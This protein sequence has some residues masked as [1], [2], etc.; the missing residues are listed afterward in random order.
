MPDSE[1]RVSMLHW[2]PLVQGADVPMPRT[3]LLLLPE[4]LVY[5]V[6]DGAEDNDADLRFYGV[7]QDA[8]ER[9]GLPLFMRS[10]LTSGKHDYRTT[11][12]VNDLGDVVSHACAVIE[13]TWLGPGEPAQAIVLREL[14]DLD[15]PFTAFDGRLPIARERRLFVADGKTI[16]RHAYWPEAAIHTPSR[17]DWRILLAAINTDLSG[18]REIVTTY[19]ERLSAVLPGAWSVD[20]ACDVQGCW[21]FIDAAPADVSWHPA[22]CPTARIGE[23]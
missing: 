8:A 21:W 2:W 12:R 13:Q 6:A 3:E 10:D 1:N 14:L 18:D 5:A 16:C 11:C 20:F 7:L 15:A 19:A 23:G 17:D 22:D 9:F 4:H